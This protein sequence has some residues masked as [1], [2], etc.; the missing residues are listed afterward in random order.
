MLVSHR[1]K[2]IFIK[3]RK[4]AG[5]SLEL[6]L[7]IFLGPDDIVTDVSPPDEITRAELGGVGSQNL[8]IPMGKWKAAD[9]RRRLSLKPV[10]FFNHFPA[11]RAREILPSEVWNGYYKFTIERNCYD[12]AVSAYFWR[13]RKEP[14]P[15]FREFLE[16]PRVT[17]HINWPLYAVENEII[18]DHVIRF[19]NLSAELPRLA[20]RVGLPAVPEMPRAKGGTRPAVSMSELYGPAERD[21]VRKLWHREIAAFGWQFPGDATMPS[22][23][24]SQAGI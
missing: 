9:W 6:A 13:N 5:T 2:F 19:E 20:E 23:E 14:R 17:R 15:P 21:L 22:G 11:S 4:T 8:K 24:P 10:R 3:T 18:V 12:L 16:S 1:H 7:S